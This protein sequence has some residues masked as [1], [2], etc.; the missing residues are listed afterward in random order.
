MVTLIPRTDML[1]LVLLLKCLINAAPDGNFSVCIMSYNSRGFCKIKQDF[2]NLLTSDNVVGNSVPILCNQENFILRAN[3]YRINNA[4]TGFHTII[5][6]A[7]KNDFNYGRPKNGMFIAVPDMFKNIIEDVSPNFWRLQAV[8]ICCTNFKLLLI[9]SYFPVDPKTMNFDESELLE[10]LNHIRNVMNMNKFDHVL[11]T[12]DINSDFLRKTG[13]VNTV[14]QFVE[15]FDFQPSWTRFNID[16]TNYHEV[17]G[18]SYTSTIDHFFWDQQLDDKILDSGVIHHPLNLS[19]HSPIY[20]KIDT[21]AIERDPVNQPS[22]PPSKPSWKKSSDLG[23]DKFI[24]HLRSLLEEIQVE[25][26]VIQCE[27]V[28]CK[29]PSHIKATDDLII[30]VLEAVDIAAGDNLHNTTQNSVKKRPPT[31]G[32]SEEVKPFQDNAFF[33]HQVWQSAGRPINTELHT[34]MKRTRNVYHYH[35]RKCKKAENS[36]RRNKLLDAC[37]NGNG[38]VFAEIKKL[39]KS[40]P[41][42]ASSM[43]GVKENVEEHFKDIYKNLYNSIDDEANILNLLDVIN[44]GINYTDT[45]DVKKVTPDIVKEAAKHLKDGKSDAVHV[46]SSACIKNAPDILFKLLSVVIRSF[47]FHG[48]V[49]MYLLLATLVPH[50]QE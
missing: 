37:L 13:H 16:F 29:E 24:E 3:S 21:A 33:W 49:T 32:W 20:C 25:D 34:I 8:I 50:N 10:T 43:D 17:N 47:L 46:F 19:D 23:K 5:K 45:H 9:N 28:H 41:V 30:K 14:K 4:L 22:N 40:T 1:F 31:P 35:V 36:I 48:H 27:N 42:V 6:P 38:E 12:G 39:R 2:C 11:W 7:V 15:E 44:N 26:E 18:V